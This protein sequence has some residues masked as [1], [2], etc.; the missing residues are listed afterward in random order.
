MING[1]GNIFENNENSMFNATNMNNAFEKGAQMD[2]SCANINN[3]NLQGNQ[4][5]FVIQDPHRED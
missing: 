5:G 2:F 1:W 3:N 4:T